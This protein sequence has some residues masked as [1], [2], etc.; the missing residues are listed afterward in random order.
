M[1]RQ[2]WWTLVAI[3]A[4]V[5]L[6]AGLPPII[7]KLYHDVQTIKDLADFAVD[8]A[9]TE[10]TCKLQG[11]SKRMLRTFVGGRFAFYDYI[12]DFLQ[13][14][15]NDTL[16]EQRLD[17][18]L[19]VTRRIQEE[20]GWRRERIASILQTAKIEA[21]GNELSRAAVAA[22]TV[23]AQFTQ[24]VLSMLAAK[25][26]AVIYGPMRRHGLLEKLA[27]KEPK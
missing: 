21:S 19:M 27:E 14:L 10:H 2:V 20:L 23:L 26:Y 16:N 13:L 25:P 9:H 8:H 18:I 24:M 22:S 6:A 12:G 5:A 15:H 17:D 3:D 1:R 11:P 4:Q 7:G